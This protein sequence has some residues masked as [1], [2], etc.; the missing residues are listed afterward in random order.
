MYSEKCYEYNIH[1]YIIF[2]N[3]NEAYDNVCRQKLFRK[4]G[5][6]NKLVNVVKVTLEEENVE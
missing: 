5:I 3:F 6:P 4:L 2:I 1:F